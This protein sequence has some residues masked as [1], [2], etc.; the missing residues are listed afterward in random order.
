MCAIEF[1]SFL[2]CTFLAKLIR[3]KI[4]ITIPKF[5]ISR[6][7]INHLAPLTV[8]FRMFCLVENLLR[9]ISRTDDS[10][11]HY[12]R[13][14]FTRSC[15]SKNVTCKHTNTLSRLLDRASRFACLRVID[16]D[17]LRANGSAVRLFELH[18]A[19]SPC[20]ACHANNHARR[21]GAS[22]GRK[23]NLVCSPRYT[24]A[25]SIVELTCT[26]VGDTLKFL[27]R[28]CNLR[29]VSCNMLIYLKFCLY[30]IKHLQGGRFRC[31]DQNDKF[32][33]PIKHC[34]DGSRLG[35]GRFARAARHGKSK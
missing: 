29:E 33:M 15:K 35:K 25:F 31:T 26:S 6:K 9:H 18:A 32:P 7:L 4:C 10:A 19:N 23:H 24:G 14:L 20:N 28:V 30:G 17:E 12:S 8:P 27:N 16:N 11:W 5:L 22:N 2:E 21:G 3:P 1:G 34:P 13:Y